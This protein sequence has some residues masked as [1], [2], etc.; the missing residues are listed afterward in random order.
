MATSAIK[1]QQILDGTLRPSIDVARM[2]AGVVDGTMAGKLVSSARIAAAR[3][4][5]VDCFLRHSSS[6]PSTLAT[7]TRILSSSQSPYASDYFHL[8]DLCGM[9]R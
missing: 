6:R 5:F 2:I 4:A 8:Y 7:F 1:H 3:V 9:G